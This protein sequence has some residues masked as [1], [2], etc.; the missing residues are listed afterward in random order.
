MGVEHKKLTGTFDYEKK[1][2]PWTILT[3][4]E[5]A[6]CVHDVQGLVEAIQIEMKHDND[7]LYTFPLTSTGYVRRDAKKALS[8]IDCRFVKNQLPNYEIYKMFVFRVEVFSF[9][10][11]IRVLFPKCWNA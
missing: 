1:R 3:D 10:L 6:Y 11:I 2:Y 7:N 5:L 4:E 8:E 9:S